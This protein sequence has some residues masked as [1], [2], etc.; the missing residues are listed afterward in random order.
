[1]NSFMDQSEE[2]KTLRSVGI[3]SIAGHAVEAVSLSH[4]GQIVF[5][6]NR[7]S[8]DFNFGNEIDSPYSVIAQNVGTF[9]LLDIEERAHAV[10]VANMVSHTVTEFENSD[11]GDRF[12]EIGMKELYRNQPHPFD[13]LEPVFEWVKDY[14]QVNNDMFVELWD[15]Y[16]EWSKYQ[17]PLSEMEGWKGWID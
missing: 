8:R 10:L 3:K 11:K 9:G 6:L 16:Q 2:A 13:H 4:E 12:R 1:M 15:V 7:N 17:P 14:H 5:Y